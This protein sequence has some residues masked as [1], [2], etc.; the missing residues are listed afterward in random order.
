MTSFVSIPQL[1]PEQLTSPQ[2]ATIEAIRQNVEMLIGDAA[3]GSNMSI[4]RNMITVQTEYSR[5]LETMSASG[6]GYK[7]N[8]VDVAAL[9]DVRNLIQDVQRLSN[10]VQTL[11]NML[12][13]L[14]VQ[15]KG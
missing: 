15:M 9:A 4:T 5:Q 3:D 10:D 7:V 1:P 11:Y 8:D 14:I 2:M 13:S 6:Y 12:N